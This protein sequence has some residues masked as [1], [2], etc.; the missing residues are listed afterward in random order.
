MCRFQWTGTEP[1][2][3]IP[4]HPEASFANKTHQN[5]GVTPSSTRISLQSNA[6]GGR[7]ALPTGQQMPTADTDLS[8][9]ASSQP[10]SLR[11]SLVELPVTEAGL[12]VFPVYSGAGPMLGYVMVA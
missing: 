12:G 8:S 5:N 4:H 10:G 7:Q 9:T 6:K 1:R 3:N 11:C 2:Y